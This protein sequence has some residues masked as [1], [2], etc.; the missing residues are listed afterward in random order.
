MAV[1]FPSDKFF[2]ENDY[3]DHGE[4]QI[5]PVVAKPQEQI[6]AEDNRNR[7][8]AENPVVSP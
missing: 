2:A 5:E 7:T 3:R 1:A 4:L 6:H 8:K